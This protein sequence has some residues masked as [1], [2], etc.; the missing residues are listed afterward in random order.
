[1]WKNKKKLLFLLA[2]SSLLI[3][4]NSS[5][6]TPGSDQLESAVTKNISSGLTNQKNYD[7][8]EKALRTRNKELK[9]LYKQSDYIV[10]PEYLEWQVFFTGFYEKSHRGG[11][12]DEKA[13]NAVSPITPL[14]EIP[15][16]KREI[17]SSIGKSLKSAFVIYKNSVNVTANTPYTITLS[18]LQNVSFPEVNIGNFIPVTVNLVT[19]EMPE[20][21]NVQVSASP[22]VISVGTPQLNKFVVLTPHIL[23]IEAPVVNDIPIVKKPATPQVP[24]VSANVFNPV[25]FNITPPVLAS[26]PVFNIKLGS[27]CNA[28]AG[29]S[30]SGV[31]LN[32]RAY[33]TG[34][35]GGNPISFESNGTNYNIALGTIGDLG[36]AL[37]NGT[38][39]LR[40]SWATTAPFNSTL[41]KV[42]FDYGT[43]NNN[44]GGTATL[45]ADLSIN[46][47]NPLSGTQKT[48]ESTQGRPWNAQSFLVGGSR[49]ATIDNAYNATL[50][51]N[52]T[53]N[54]VGPLVVGFE[55]QTDTNYSQNQGKR[56]LINRK[57]ITDAEETV[58]AA[59]NAVLPVS[60][61]LNLT[62]PPFAGGGT[63]TVTR[64]SA[65]F[66]GY[67]VG[68]ML[69]YENSDSN[70][71]NSYVLTNEASG[72]IDFKGEKSIGIQIYAPDSKNV[73]VKVS[74]Q[75]II[76]MGGIESYGLKL[77]SRANSANMVFNNSGTIN[78][79][80]NNGTNSSRS[81]GMAVI[82]DPDL[83]GG[84]SV[85]AYTNVVTNSGN[86]N[87]SGGYGN[88]GMILK[89]A[90][91]DN[92]TNSGIINVNGTSNMGMRVDYG[93]VNAGAAGSPT[94]QNNKIINVNDIRNLAIIANGRG[95][96]SN[97][98]TGINGSTGIINISGTNSVGLFS[99]FGGNVTNSASGNISVSGSSSLGIVVSDNTSAG[100]NSGIINITGGSS[101]GVYNMGTFNM[102]GGSITASA[103]S[104][105]GIYAKPSSATSITG[106]TLTVS[107]GSAAISAEN[108]TVSMAGS[109]VNVNSGGLFFYRNGTGAVS[110]TSTINVNHN[111]TAFYITGGNIPNLSSIIISGNLAL[112]MAAGST[113]IGWDQPTGILSLNSLSGTLGTPTITNAAINDL[114]GGTY[115]Y[116]VINKA[117]VLIDRNTT[118]YGTGN[119]YFPRIS[120]ISSSVQIGNSYTVSGTESNQIGIAQRN[121]NGSSGVNAIV[122]TNNGAVNL[123]GSDSTGIAGDY[124]TINNSG[125][126][127]TTGNKSTGIF[128]ANGSQVTNTGII[129]VNTTGT[130]N[131]G[132][133]IYGTNQFDSTPVSY[134][135]GKINIINAG[136][137]TYGGNS[138]SSG[139]GIYVDNNNSLTDSTITLNT[140]SNIDM[141][142]SSTGVGVFADNSVINI[143]GG[144]IKTGNTTGIYA[145]GGSQINASSGSIEVDS[146][147]VGVYLAGNS[148]YNETGSQMTKFIITGDGASLFSVEAG[149]TFNLSPLNIDNTTSMLTT[150]YKFIMGS[151]GDIAY[152]FNSTANIGNVENATI[153]GT[154]GGVILLDTLSNLVSA[155]GNTIGVGVSSPKN[156]SVS[157]IS[158][159]YEIINNG[160]IILTGDKSTGIYSKSGAKALNAGTA[161]N[162][163][164]IGKNSAGMYTAGI[165]SL[166]ENVGNIII[167]EG[168]AALYSSASKSVLTEAGAI[169]NGNITSQEITPGVYSENVT[170]IYITSGNEG[171]Q[172]GGTISFKGNWST[173]I[174]NEGSFNMTG[175]TV[176]LQSLGG[177]AVYSKGQVSDTEIS[178]GIIEVQN[179][180][181]A[182]YADDSTVKVS[183]GTFNIGADGL[184]MYNYSSGGLGAQGQL[185]ISNSPV[186]VINNGGMGF[187]VEGETLAGISGILNNLV[188]AGSTGTMFLDMKN[189]SS[190]LRWNIPIN[191]LFLSGIPSVGTVNRIDYTT[192]TAPGTDYKE[193][194]INL[195]ELVI[196]K[197]VVL[198][199]L[200]NAYDGVEMSRSKVT[201]A[202]GYTITDSLDGQVAIAQTN[203]QRTTPSAGDVNDIEITNNGNINLTGKSATGMAADYGLINNNASGILSIAGE[204][205][206]GIL[207]A[208]GSIVTNNG[209][210][211]ITGENSAGIYARNYFDGTSATSSAA[212]GYGND[213]INISNNGKIEILPSA[214]LNS[215]YGIYLDNSGAVPSNMS[216]LT[217][218]T[219]SEIIIGDGNSASANKNTGISLIN[220]TLTDNGGTM[221][222]GINGLGI[223]AK[224]SI[225]RGTGSIRTLN[226]D[227]VGYYFEGIVDSDLQMG[228]IEV[229]GDDLAV[230]YLQDYTAA[231]INTFDPGNIE[232]TSTN[233]GT[234]IAGIIGE[235]R[236]VIMDNQITVRKSLN[237][238]L[239]GTVIYAGKASL[240]FDTN[241]QIISEEH[242][243][244]GAASNTRYAGSSW[245]DPSNP[246]YELVFKGKMDLKNNSVGI[247]ASEGSRVL[248]DTSGE[249]K[250]GE[251]S[252]GMYS[253]NLTTA[254]EALNRGKIMLNGS[255]ASGLRADGTSLAVNT[256]IIE[257]LQDTLGAYY[258]DVQGMVVTNGASIENTGIITLNGNSSTG[259]YNNNGDVNMTAGSIT[260]S[261]NQSVGV[262]SK[263]SSSSTLISGGVIEAKG[264]ADGS[265]V[266]LFAENSTIKI[267][268]GALLK[269]SNNGIL[270]YT[271]FSGTAPTGNFDL[272]SG[273][274]QAEIGADGIGFYHIGDSSD[275]GIQ[276][277]LNTLLTGSGTLDVKLTDQSSKL[278][279]IESTGGV[280]NLSSLVPGTLTMLSGTKVSVNPSSAPVHD[281]FLIN[282]GELN[283]DQN[284]NLDNVNDAYN[285][286]TFISSK[287][288]L[289]PGV[290]MTGSTNNQN[291]IVQKNFSGG[292]RADI[293]L[294]NNGGT[295]ILSGTDSIGM[296]ADYGE[297]IN[298]GTITI[299]GPDSIA[300]LGANGTKIENTGTIN[301]ASTGVGIY[302]TNLLNTTIPLYG[303]KKIEIEND[304]LITLT[305]SPGRGYGIYAGNLDTAVPLSD[306]TVLLGSNSLIDMSAGSDGVGVFAQRSSLTI[307]GGINTGTRGIGV[308]TENSDVEINSLA[309]NLNG[310]NGTGLYI[311]GNETLTVNGNVDVTAAGTDNVIFYF[312]STGHVYGLGENLRILNT[313][314]GASFI[315]GILQTAQFDF[316]NSF[317]NTVELG[318][319]SVTGI[320]GQNSVIRFGTNVT[321]NGNGS[322]QTAIFADGQSTVPF[323]T[324]YT[325][326]EAINEGNINLQNDSTG[327]YAKNGARVF[328]SGNI[329][330]EDNSAGISV[331]DTGS[332]IENTGNISVGK[333]SDA[334]YLK[335]GD[336]VINYG[337]LSGIKEDIIGIHSD[338][339][340]GSVDNYGNITLLGNQSVG[341]YT[342]GNNA[343]TVNNYGTITVGDS[344]NILNSSTGIYYSNSAPGI[345]NSNNI[346]AGNKSVGIYSLE[347]TVNQNG[348]LKIGNE[349]IGIYSN[350]GNAVFGAASTLETGNNS[351]GVYSQQ[352]EIININTNN[353]IKI[354]D[355]SFGFVL[356]NGGTINTA[357]TAAK[358]EIGENSTYIHADG[359]SSIIN[360]LNIL[361]NGNAGN[362]FVISGGILTNN[363][364]ITGSGIGNTG[365]YIDSGTVVNNA[366]I[367]LGESL[368]VLNPD[369]TVNT[370]ASN[371]S[372][373]IYGINSKITNNAGV[374]ITIGKNGV[375]IYSE[376]SETNIAGQP[377]ITNNGNIKST[378]SGA[379]GMY[380]I[381]SNT[382]NNGLIELTG[383]DSTGI[384]VQNSTVTNNGNIIMRGNNS[385]GI[386]VLSG[387]VID[388]K[389]SIKIY[390]ANSTGILA[391]AGTIILNSGN[392]YI[393]SLVSG[394]SEQIRT[395][396][397]ITGYMAPIIKTSGRIVVNDNF[398]LDGLDLII[399]PD[400]ST[401]QMAAAS[402]PHDFIIYT[403][404]N[405]YLQAGSLTVADP[406]T[407]APTYT[408]GT[409]AN[410]Y[411]IENVILTNSGIISTPTGSML[412]KSG[413][414]TWDITPVKN[415]LGGYD[416]YAERK[417]YNLFTSGLWFEEFGKT[418]EKN[419]LT[420][421]GYDER[422]EIYDKIDQITNEENFRN[423]I[424]SLAGDIYANINQREKTIAGIFGSSLDLLQNSKN[425]TKENVKI[426]VIAGKGTVEEN[427]SGV[428]D[429]DY[430]TAGV[431]ALREVERTYRHTFGY[432]L[433]YAHTSFEFDDGNDSEEWVDTIQLG[434][435]NK[436]TAG[437]WIFRNDLMG[438]ASNHNIDRNIDW[439]GSG[440]SEM[441]GNFQTY[442]ITSDN[443]F[444]RK[445][446]MNKNSNLTPYAGLE[447]MYVIRPA[448]EEEGLERLKVDKNDAW[449][450]K[451]KAGIK[452]D[453]S[454]A[455]G[456]KTDWKLKG[457]LD[458]S[459]EYELADLDEREK[460]RLVAVEDGY[461]DLA[462]PQDEYGT[463][464]T[465]AEIGAEVEDRYGFFLTGEYSAG[466]HDQEDFRVGV[467]LKAVF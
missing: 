327:I 122:L 401:L 371:Y 168:S 433:G 319:N 115:K 407:I 49:I 322:G 92:I 156:A 287:V 463:V 356:K 342:K 291:A 239:E 442:S 155:G 221:T 94:A 144:T 133:G 453:G 349:S 11:N 41:L 173:G 60:S 80:G 416:I 220:S 135:T 166:V 452:L 389:G 175:G 191:T 131:S 426:N 89:L 337:N 423:N 187:Y 14:A 318:T 430:E 458:L 406:I 7:I 367:T 280:T 260:V 382:V 114:S 352:S 251:N 295:I 292:S 140:G 328:N 48:T 294:N 91:A 192:L 136:T 244:V 57:T 39:A 204:N 338:T 347:S 399:T 413:S 431:L 282:K 172:K 23:Q 50:V 393:D 33:S 142:A 240:L 272:V 103:P 359:A 52:G 414:L 395:D 208:N 164:S 152:T 150:P 203:Y 252:A 256:G 143:N 222:V 119:Q 180:S 424:S 53:I 365:V 268:N 227:S 286:S 55:M 331:R 394:T 329:N 300:L 459:Y 223:Y 274:I 69:T 417:D 43:K 218:G 40:Y 460:A 310:N 64:N 255:G 59:L 199:F 304:G 361:M 145:I 293:T 308:Y 353:D 341:I 339:I 201:L 93:T 298:S 441:N 360:N 210:V 129:N 344:A 326:F 325:G 444:G 214:F 275:S 8:I 421:N 354:G 230:Y 163:I 250:I 385:V 138:T 412:M 450:V 100:T 381:N 68:L 113:L 51:N 137:I 56:E 205:S 25:I 234:F 86:I 196:D 169:N 345:I 177:V 366:D 97:R 207:A 455:L 26:P 248:N 405:P 363:G 246:N 411:K 429:Y 358:V 42:Y 186:A 369:N 228:S 12:S 104:S 105:V 408:K 409:T 410:T 151:V 330:I 118:L 125:T 22:S 84:S 32:G 418:L 124:A 303:D 432:S 259:I 374:D 296:A 437:D 276:T 67:K 336:T 263:D 85:R 217:L 106:G 30:C 108:S 28:M 438:R 373:G 428:V 198:K 320:T 66:T 90:A 225:L 439:D 219:N 18:P 288:T 2:F 197:N 202:A 277:F 38:P 102:N 269:T 47:I 206:V 98:A 380:T 390:G 273:V 376:S 449:S 364:N 422:G 443:T 1:M 61:S 391:A 343:Q 161:G 440:R 195:G 461:H 317:N 420:S 242:K 384:A 153:F 27:Y 400:P 355:G 314:P 183:G 232:L 436:Y 29:S 278:F 372:V 316:T 261:G 139:A 149:S 404:K 267:D 81:A 45:T 5:D 165:D 265:A 63:I 467:S 312:N 283:I 70:S 243:I 96:G 95:N 290:T 448:F 306:S 464:K 75:G 237:N 58:S 271:S 154:S 253:V 425:N 346:I 388:N 245:A 396:T 9:D 82:E 190:L 229:N 181:V 447:I 174:F 116:F 130:A 289:A 305:S 457:V 46:S 309:L 427:T 297:I 311:T 301:I 170:G 189:G 465:R 76:T 340:T 167:G 379:F 184:L 110:G 35:I 157:Y 262:Y 128:A 31:N 386:H 213:S 77:S 200:G 134:G 146:G 147:G 446:A 350:G 226:E 188:S 121:Y 34:A 13:L 224:D 284:V 148:Q 415:S 101:A 211:R 383:D 87:V 321:V 65:G 333:G 158:G 375:G 456:T 194:S 398:K 454:M 285:R 176:T 254:S 270:F 79:S 71:A 15:A 257:S 370:S 279:V 127:T 236:S 313:A 466:S 419:Y 368:I 332:R 348:I 435:H 20:T 351:V 445:F 36:G 182:L 397:T 117:N 107:N 99:T 323:I 171:H 238:A 378:S 299:S 160:K 258:E 78:I 434:A 83:T 62:L 249:I 281:I 362:G 178:G 112:N 307:N 10:K 193:Y 334:L 21:V 462:K 179:G 19:P 387:S 266:T 16:P 88:S 302:G 74:N 44:P 324:G 402:D 231:G 235:N 215:V 392:I 162:L 109:T 37:T 24:T 403:S 241:F 132:V 111:G 357:V 141:S 377:V 159:S 120:F 216:N 3:A 17:I 72:L 264:N 126:I 4:Q 54:L 6:T 209:T 73:P 451:P 335:D 212:L 123:S 185:D 233:G 247:Y 315:L